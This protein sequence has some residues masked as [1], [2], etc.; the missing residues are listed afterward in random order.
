[1]PSQRLWLLLLLG[2]CAFTVASYQPAFHAGFVNFD[3]TQYLQGASPV[4]GGL[5]REGVRWALTGY[6]GSN[7]HPLTWISHMADVEL[8]GY[9][10]GWHHAENVA[11]HVLNVVLLFLVLRSLTGTPGPS[12]AVAALFALHPVD[13]ESVAWIPQRKTLLSTLF[14]LLSIYSYARYAR[15]G[16]LRSYALSLL[17]L[18]MSLASKS[19]FVTLPFALLL[20]DYWPLQ[21]PAFDSA[22]GRT[23]LV[24]LVRGWLRLLPEKIPYALL[25]A[26]V[27]WITLDAQKDAMSS[28]D[29]LPLS[30]RLA[31]VSV[32]YVKYLGIFFAPRKLAAFYPLRPESL[33][34]TVVL[35]SA[36]LLVAIT[37]A[38]VWFG[39]RRRFLLV[40]WLWFLGTLIPVI[41]L[42]QVGR[43]A[44]ADR[45]A[46]VPFWG[47]AIAVVW[48]ARNL[49]ASR[50]PAATARA[51]GVAVL[52]PL[53]CLLAVLTWR[54]T[55]VWHD[56]IR[57]FESA[58]ANTQ[59]NWLAHGALAERY[60]AKSEFQ[61]AIEHSQEALRFKRDVGAVRSTYGLALYATGQPDKALEQ[62]E[63]AVLQDPDNPIGY[64][65]LGWIQIERGNYDTA[66]ERLAAGAAKISHTTP[67]YTRKMIY[68]N[69]ANALVK[70]DQLPAARRMYVRALEIEPHAPP[71]VRDIARVD[72]QLGDT[73]AA[74]TGLRKALEMDATDLD[75]EYLLAAAVLLQGHPDEAAAL[76]AKAAAQDPRKVVVAIDFARGLAHQGHR[77]QAFRILDALLA[78]PPPPDAAD[79]SFVASTVETQRAEIE[80]E[81]SDAAAAI[82]SL[83]RALSIWPDNY[84]ANNRLAFLLA[85]SGDPALRDANRAVTLAERATAAR[86]EFGSLATLAAAYA[87][88]G[89]LPAAIQITKEAQGLAA[90][91]NDARAVTALER[92]ERLYSQAAGGV[93]EAPQ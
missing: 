18:G 43:Q 52:M 41:G 59:D 50:W 5:T 3:D 72:L 14:A 7:W 11:L 32:A 83:E 60:Y 31:N 64:M 2:L 66:I 68:A 63:L 84:D 90:K 92:Q 25:S 24:A 33:A 36:A 93:I 49:L 35:A 4:A 56:G 57:L 79:A 62:F 30:E 13:V 53:L 82:A 46:Y 20:L 42:V 89:R 26:C 16:G 28:I 67:L 6:Y 15:G 45:Y 37:M 88:A 40:G 8:F 47:L 58:V 17:W 55:R 85:T 91:A 27:M 71:V 9:E 54:Q 12:L 1:M 38:A 70:T 44:L 10:L 65:N 76:F 77:D 48:S 87:A 23:T 81:G 61:K 29:M 74:V 39:L 51:I 80:L 22:S 21:R 75:T 78:I 86:R 69:W 34:P 73:D 19:M